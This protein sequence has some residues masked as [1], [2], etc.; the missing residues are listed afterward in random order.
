[1]IDL[2]ERIR[3]IAPFTLSVAVD[4]A[5]AIGEALSYAHSQG[6]AHGDLRPNNVIVSPEGHAK[7]TDFGV[8]TAMR[9][10]RKGYAANREKSV[11]Y[12]APEISQGGRPSGATDIYSL[13]VILFEML[14]GALPYPGETIGVVAERHIS[15]PVPSARSLNPGVPRS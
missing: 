13:G 14:T 2:K 1:G 9:D 5:I 7:V 6:I 4:F 10:S 12:D 15:D 3:R 8:A 11:H